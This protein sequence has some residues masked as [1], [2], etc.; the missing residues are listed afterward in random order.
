MLAVVFGEA[1]AVLDEHSV[2]GVSGNTLGAVLSAIRA[3]T[4]L[5]ATHAP[6]RVEVRGEASDSC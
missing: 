4:A 2:L 1:V 3:S 6:E 5:G